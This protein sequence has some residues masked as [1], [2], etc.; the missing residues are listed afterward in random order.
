MITI[1]PEGGLANRMRA[2]DSAYSLSK[3]HNKK[4]KVIWLRN[5]DL[6]CPFNVLFKP[7]NKFKIKNFTI[8][9]IYAYPS[10]F[11]LKAKFIKKIVES[12][13]AY[14]FDKALLNN[15]FHHIIY[16]DK[17]S[18]SIPND[19]KKI[20][21]ETCERFNSTINISKLF[22]PTNSILKKVSHST[23]QFSKNTIG[24]HIRGTDNLAAIKAGP[25]SYFADRIKSEIALDPLSNFYISTDE[26]DVKSQLIKLFGDKII[27]RQ[28]NYK[29]H[30]IDGMTDAL[31]DFICL[32]KT[33]KIIGSA[34][35]SFSI[36]AANYGNIEIDFPPKEKNYI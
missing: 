27:T 3:A 17:K 14:I 34:H 36:E 18:V 31:V 24:I 5:N 10:P 32:S 1:V 11:Q 30:T 6:N 22:T 35:S 20:Y 16:I 9:D 28:I 21:I 23:N 13:R 25:L 7:T 4:L 15:F 29:R 26:E 33:K 8:F 12:Y 2:V 19:Y